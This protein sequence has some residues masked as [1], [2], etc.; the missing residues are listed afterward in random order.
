MAEEKHSELDEDGVTFV[1]LPA[2]GDPGSGHRKAPGF[3]SQAEEESALVDASGLPPDA[4]HEA[5]RYLERELLG[6]GGM[7]KIFLQHDG[8]IGRDVAMKVL[9]TRYAKQAD[10]LA[11]FVR[12][13]RIQGQ[14]EH[15]S[16]VPVYDLMRRPNGDICFT[17][18]RVRGK[19][20]EQIVEGIAR[21]DKALIE[22]YPRR[23]LLRNFATACLA[24]DFAHTRGVL[25]RDLK[26]SNIMLGD[27]GE[28]YVLDWGLSKVAGLPDIPVRKHH[29]EPQVALPDDT[30][31]RTMDGAVLGT[32]GY[33]SPEQ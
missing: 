32:P 16:I 20:I 13:A 15:P 7:G 6:E 19:T 23:K 21:K 25:H 33:M 2:A 28:I 5:E 4:T 27:H 11:R 1:K 26:P 14:L 9:R 30:G 24:V 31:T 17:M 18:K 8:R 10:T 29:D 3:A 22:A 12:E